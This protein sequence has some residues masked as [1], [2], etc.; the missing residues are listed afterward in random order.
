MLPK[1]RRLTQ[2]VM[3]G[4]MG[5]W[6]FY[7]IFR[8]PF[9]VPFV[10]CQTCPV[11]TCWG[12][13]TAY[14]WSFWIIFPLLAIFLGRTFCSWICPAGFV[15]QFLGKIALWKLRIPSPLLKAATW[16]KLVGLAVIAF[17]YYGTQNLRA[18]P[19]I[20][21]GE[22][23]N[24]VL[25]NFQNATLPW[26]VRTS[27]VVGLIVASLIIANLWCRFAC[28]TGGLLELIKRFSIF[29]VYKT[30]ACDDCNA[31]L[32]RCE[33]GTRPNEVNCTNCGDCLKVCHKD[34]IKFGRPKK[35]ELS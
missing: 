11:I 12:R 5:N 14:F 20:R 4:V 27:V 10:N 8:C 24:S 23:F 17:L 30:K 31:C 1:I 25:L 21:T 29:K 28:P 6:S 9:M 2:A 35:E 33:M 34:A 26:L 32:R 18:L 13:L 15:N 22:Y 7:G 19:P 16:G 3:L